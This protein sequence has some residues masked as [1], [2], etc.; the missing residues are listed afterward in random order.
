MNKISHY[1]NTQANKDNTAQHNKAK[2]SK[3]NKAQDKRIK[4]IK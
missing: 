1:E 2:I 3:D 4:K